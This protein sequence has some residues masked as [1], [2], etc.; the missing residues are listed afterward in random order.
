M[1]APH[2][3]VPKL[4]TFFKI[5]GEPLNSTHIGPITVTP[6]EQVKTY[7]NGKLYAGN[8]ADIP[9]PKH[10]Q[11]VIEV[12]PPFVKPPTFAFGTL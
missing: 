12:G 10:Q 4:V 2:K 7:V 6:G 9:L 3:I 1:E 8:P 5:W 11:V